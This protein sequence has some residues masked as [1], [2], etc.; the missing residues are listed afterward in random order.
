MARNPSVQEFIEDN[1][2]LL[3]AEERLLEACRVGGVCRLGTRPE[4]YRADREV[5]AEFLKVL[6]LGGTKDCDLDPSRVW[7]EGAWI[8]GQ[9]NLSYRRAVGQIVLDNCRFVAE[10][11][12]EQAR[13]DSLSLDGSHLPGLWAQGVQAKGDLFLRGITATGTVAVNGAQI[14]GQL[15]CTGATLDGAGGKAL[16]A[17]GVTCGQDLF[18]S[19]ITATGTV[20]VDGAQ[21]G[22]QVDCT[23]ATLNGAGGRAL[24]AQALRAEQGLVWRD[25]TVT[26][27]QVDLIAAHVS[28]L[29]DDLESWPVDRENRP[30][31][32]NLIL[33]GFTYDRIVGPLGAAERIAWLRNG[34][35]WDGEFYPQPYRQLARVLWNMGHDRAARQVRMALAEDMA[36]HE[37]FLDRH[38]RRVLA[39]LRKFS[40]RPGPR[41]RE[42]VA[43]TVSELPGHRAEV[44]TTTVDKLLALHGQVD[45]NHVPPGPGVQPISETTRRYAQRQFRSDL[46]W[47]ELGLRARIARSWVI[48]HLSNWVIGYGFAPWRSIYWLV[49]LMSIGATMAALTW[50][51]G[52]FAPNSAPILVSQ[53][54]HDALS[55]D[56][57]AQ[58]WSDDE[59]GGKDWDSFSALAYGADVVIPIVPFG[60][61]DAWAPSTRGPW[62]TGLW[63]GRWVLTALGWIVTAL[64]AAAVTG[65]IQRDKD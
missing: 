34:T 17:Q 23:G 65:L 56:N 30:D 26:K 10:P 14:G 48:D 4:V 3:A 25:V 42:R 21:F 6:I 15:D 49:L 53:G 13:F 16:H 54:W 24:F 64:G 12:I 28:N 29:V 20:N 9:L 27:G 40:A 8:S 5:R 19:G 51:E 33:D 57:P 2:P 31:G 39:A 1:G 32:G 7:L 45:P 11:R 55:A 59:F 36:R 62:G 41:R 43:K 61:T 44:A 38:S 60:Q 35:K 46:A 58:V 47:Q 22:G 63:W 52:S 50:K 37:R 18:L